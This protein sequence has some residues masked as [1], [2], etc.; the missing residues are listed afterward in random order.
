MGDVVLELCAL[1][2]VCSLIDR[3]SVES[4]N[5][6]RST[7]HL[8]FES[9]YMCRVGVASGYS[10]VVILGF[11]CTVLGARLP[12]KYVSLVIL[13]LHTSFLVLWMKYSRGVVVYLASSVVVVS[14]L[15]KV[16]LAVLLAAREIE[17]SLLERVIYPFRTP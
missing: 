14:E 13:T 2:P 11:V 1:S 4:K 9:V 7:H 12:I 17:A 6:G 5:D 16:V 8:R 15:C 10:L 3:G